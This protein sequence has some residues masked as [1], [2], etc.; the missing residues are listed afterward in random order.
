MPGVKDWIAK[1]SGD[2]KSSKKLI[3]ADRLER[4]KLILLEI[5]RKHIPVCDVYLFGSRAR[6][7]AREGADLDVALDAGAPIKFG[8]LANIAS[9]VEESNIPLFVDIV[10]M[11]NI[12]IEM[13]KEIE[14]EGLLWTK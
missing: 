13:R 7:T 12:S 11:H 4:Y 5:V 10:D 8:T 14:K 1:V 9:D 3:K 6:G 2:L